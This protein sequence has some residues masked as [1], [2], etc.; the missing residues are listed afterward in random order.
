M[1][2]FRAIHAVTEAVIEL[3]R[4]SYRQE[5]FNNALEFDVFTSRD[6]ANPL[7]NGVSL[8]LYRI[9]PHG[10]SRIPAGTI[11]TDGRRMQSRL[12]LELHFLLTIWAQRPSLQ[13]SIAGWMMRV[14]ENYPLL[15]TGLLNSASPQS[16]GGKETVEIAVAD[17]RTEDLMRIWEALDTAV[18]QLSVP[19]LARVVSIE[20]DEP[21]YGTGVGDVRERQQEVGVVET[22]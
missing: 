13:H 16:F 7:S 4:S 9:F 2:D 12:P 19:Y 15:P 8:F 22:S 21:V 5:D 18:Y 20:S 11:G 6:F 1:A 17:L 3:L 14:L 10:S